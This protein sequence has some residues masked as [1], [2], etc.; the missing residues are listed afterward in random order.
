[1]L[2][3][4][5]LRPRPA[6]GL[7]MRGSACAYPWHR[8]GR[9]GRARRSPIDRCAHLPRVRGA[10]QALSHFSRVRTVYTELS[11]VCACACDVPTRSVQ[12]CTMQHHERRGA[13]PCTRTD[14]TVHRPEM[15]RSA[16]SRIGGRDGH[17][18]HRSTL[19]YP[20]VTSVPCST[21]QYPAVPSVPCSTLQYPAVP[22][23]PCGTL[24]TLRY[25][26]VPCSTLQ[27]PAVPFSTLQYP[28]AVAADD[29]THTMQPAAYRLPHTRRLLCRSQMP[30]WS[31]FANK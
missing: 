5:V 23:V 13:Q 31:I 4:L 26:S 28:S 18:K 8:P 15:G 24:S 14:C 29:A 7:S 22:S 1:V 20:A 9:G 17:A 16:P 12:P 3:L 30:K 19:Q 11:K 6:V 2:L 25:P 10:V 27:Y 21:L